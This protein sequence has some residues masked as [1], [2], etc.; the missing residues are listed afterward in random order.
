MY[1]RIIP[2]STRS[3]LSDLIPVSP[4]NTTGWRRYI[5]SYNLDLHELYTVAIS[6]VNVLSNPEDEPQSN[7]TADKSMTMVDHAT[8]NSSME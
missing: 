2:R 4:L 3:Y 1:L 5:Q 8:D 6:I 7:E